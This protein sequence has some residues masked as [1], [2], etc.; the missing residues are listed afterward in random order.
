MFVSFF[1]YLVLFD[2][3]ITFAVP[4]HNKLLYIEVAIMFCLPESIYLDELL[5]QQQF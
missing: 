3:Y 4:K 1:I 2:I 5:K